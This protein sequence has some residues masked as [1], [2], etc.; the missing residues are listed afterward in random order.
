[1]RA[2]QR[3]ASRGRAWNASLIS[4]ST[5][6]AI[7]SIALLADPDMYGRGGPTLLV[8]VSVLTLVAS[9]V[10]SG[11]DYSGRSRNMFVNYRKIQRLSAEAERAKDI[12]EKQTREYVDALNTQYDALLDES[13]NHTEA[14]HYRATREGKRTWAVWRELGLSFGPYL[15]LALPIALLIPFARWMLE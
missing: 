11:L 3:L 13:E 14:D 10:T 8:C 2:S 5:S 9:L 6:T 12:P 1:M 7:A 15:S 4:L